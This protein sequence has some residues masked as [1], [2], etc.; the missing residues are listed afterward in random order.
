MKTL[1]TVADTIRRHK[2]LSPGERI[3]IALSGGADSV[4]LFLILKELGYDCVLAHC[5]FLLR[6]DE[7]YRD[8]TF[9][10]N[11]AETHGAPLHVAHWDTAAIAQERGISIEMAARDLRYHWFEVIAEK[12]KIHT[13][14]TGHHAADNAETFFLNLCRGTGITGLTGIQ[15]LSRRHGLRIVRPLIRLTREEIEDFLKLRKQPF[16]VDSTNADTTYRRNLIRQELLPLLRRINPSFDEALARTMRHL[17]EAKLGL[18]QYTAESLGAICTILPDGISINA[19]SLRY[20]NAPGVILHNV[21]SYYGFP[22]SLADDLISH[23]GEEGGGLYE[24]GDYL[25]SRNRDL[26]EVRRRPHSFDEVLLKPGRNILPDGTH[27]TMETREGKEI[28]RNKNIACID[29]RSFLEPLKC[30]TTKRGDRFAPYGMRGSKLVSD[31]LCDRGYSRISRLGA[32][33][34]LSGN[35][36]VWV[37]GERP[38]GRYAISHATRSHVRLTIE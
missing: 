38:A 17:D 35:D 5:N 10:R 12:E 30:R 9:V 19:E 18:N 32:K 7:S 2:L 36:I 1:Q 15:P 28:V 23:L 33:V 25:L 11:L 22:P 3:L 37:V 8:E 31:Y 21:I 34:I 16:V 29:S 4:A 26:I 20:C 14:C 13:L 27:I 6:D 24:A